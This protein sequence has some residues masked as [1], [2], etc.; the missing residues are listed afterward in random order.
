MQFPSILTTAKR[1]SERERRPQA[2][3]GGLRELRGKGFPSVVQERQSEVAAVLWYLM[4]NGSFRLLGHFHVLLAVMT[5]H[6]SLAFPG[7]IGSNTC[8]HLQNNFI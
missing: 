6:A 3:A 4:L 7:N 2:A 8:M 1:F 5:S